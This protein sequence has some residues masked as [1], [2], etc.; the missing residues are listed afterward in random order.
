MVRPVARSL[1]LTLLGVAALAACGSDDGGDAERFCGEILAH[2]DELVDPQLTFADDI[3]PLL[4]LYRDIGRFAPLAVEREW[5]QLVTNYETAATVVP[6]DE[7]SEQ[8][9]IATALQSERSAAAV[10]AWLQENC[11]IDL[12]PVD[13][14]VPQP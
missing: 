7:E 4:E 5:D 11:G 14:L 10:D 13:T 8:R 9:A 1:G 2:R 12:G 6:G 3:D